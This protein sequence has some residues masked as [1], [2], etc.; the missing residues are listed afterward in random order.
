MEFFHIKTSRVTIT[1]VTT[2]TTATVT[3]VTITA[4]TITTFTTATV[5]LFFNEKKGFWFKKKKVLRKF[6]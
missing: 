4:V 6:S 1:N 5:T 2:V 3:A